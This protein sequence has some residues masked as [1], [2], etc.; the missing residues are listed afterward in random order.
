MV[1]LAI[2]LGVVVVY[3]LVASRLSRTIIS[4]PVIFVTF[5]VLISEEGLG[6][7][8]LELDAE[9]VQALLKATLVVLLFTEASELRAGQLREEAFIPGRLLFVALPLVIGFGL[10]AAALLFDQIG[11]W[12]AA[13]LAAI[14]APTDAALGQAVVANKRV[15]APIRRS[16]VVESGLND[17][18]AFPL[19][20]AFAGAAEVAEG[21]ETGPSF[22]E[23]LAS[24]V[25]L[26]LLAGVVV[27]WLGAKA[28]NWAVE[29]GWTS[30]LWAQ[31]A[32]LAIAGV[33][34]A[35]AEAVDGNGFISAWIAGLSFGYFKEETEMPVSHFGETTSHLLT[36]ISFL[37]FGALLLAPLLG[38]V[39][40]SVL[41]YGIISLVLVRPLAV[42][43]SMISS[44]LRW[45]TTAYMGWFGPRGIA[46][47]ILAVIILKDFKL[48][49]IDLII[50]V[51]TVTVAASVYL[52]G[53]TAWPGSNRYADWYH[54]A[55]PGELGKYA[56][57]TEEPR[58]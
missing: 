8:T 41:I 42:G 23:F 52:H 25:G 47:I 40:S 35:L 46:S 33:S 5:G 56:Q 3:A 53:V 12:E 31:I 4:G 48:P 18:L 45:P 11:I 6:L 55:G 51:M 2:V 54:R 15:P 16:L 32:F 34:F 1:S 29:K 13:A 58:T 20:L 27:G 37:V 26:G 28:L 57:N 14:L 24:Q 7:F 19:A 21:T 50:V 10:V 38:E 17:G 39:S 43:L 30:S 49:H 44:H 22:L 36:L 9:L